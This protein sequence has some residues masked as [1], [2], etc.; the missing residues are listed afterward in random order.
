MSDH[1]SS[2]GLTTA[3]DS[4][5]PEGPPDDQNPAVA[6]LWL[7]FKIT[8]AGAVIYCGVIFVYLFLL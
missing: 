6:D 3:H 1:D 7:T 5:V 2:H 8:L 4:P